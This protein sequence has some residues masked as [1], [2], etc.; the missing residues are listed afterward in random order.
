MQFIFSEFNSLI[1]LLITVLVIGQEENHPTFEVENES[2][3]LK[4]VEN[5]ILEN[6]GM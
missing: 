6:K 1:F 5:T 3:K 2:T 4:T